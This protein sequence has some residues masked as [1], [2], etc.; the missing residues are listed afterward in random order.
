LK[1]NLL[2]IC[3]L[4]T[5]NACVNSKSSISEDDKVAEGKI[6]FT[7][8]CASCHSF[9]NDGIGPNLTG[10]GSEIDQE[11]IIN[12]IKNPKKVIE[13][14]NERAALLEAKYKTIMPSFFFL[15]NEKIEAIAAYIDTFKA[16]E[17][18]KTIESVGNLED[19]IP[20]GIEE[21]NLVVD[22]KLAFL[23]PNSNE[24]LP[25]TRIAKLEPHP[26]SKELY[27]L[28][29]N[30][31][32]YKIL[33][34]QPVEYMD[35]SALMPK[36]LRQ[37]GLASGFGNYA[38][39]PEFEE[40]GLLFTSHTEPAG[41]KKADFAYADSIPVKLQWV[42]QEWK[43]DK[44]NQVPFEGENRELFRIDM[45]TQIHGMQQLAFNSTAKNGDAD[46]GNL[47]VG[48][49]DGGASERGFDFLTNSNKTPWG[50]IFRINPLGNN[51]KNGKYGIPSDNPF[52][53]NKDAA[54]EVFANGF[55]NPHRFTWTRDGKLIA[56][57][58][59][60]QRIESVYVIQKGN[61]YGWPYREGTFEIKP[62][63]DMHQVFPLPENDKGVTYPSLQYDHDE[64][65][66]VCG[67]FVY[68]GSKIPALKGKY[69]FGDIVKGRLF[70]AEESKM[71]AG[72]NIPFNEFQIAINGI[73]TTL[74]ELS[75]SEHAKLRLGID[76]EGEL[77]LFSMNDG[78]VYEL[79]KA[80]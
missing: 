74:K 58:I 32:L 7:N 39:H 34:N 41:S 46:Y 29:H 1:N 72:K 75:K 63:G 5:F 18:K 9:V 27:I 21:S 20:F 56:A 37:P 10:L 65:N 16:I 45:V 43:T 60:H 24:G 8:N 38:F 33:N 54:K 23:V 62:S 61:N 14:G 25:H 36:F 55:R 19:P 69:V 59:G 13:A 11:E 26:T 28:D 12:F 47:Y 78:K 79:N 17:K 22:L 44:P 35:M 31:K 77:Y 80:L 71:I 6:Q 76:A 3:A 4:I 52:Y 48:I 70:Y 30:N 50:S 57:N 67:G 42:L 66:A 15:G 49:G 2:I 51:S 53:G 64:G 40:N 68:E 73:K